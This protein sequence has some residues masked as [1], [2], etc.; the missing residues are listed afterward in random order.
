MSAKESAT[1]KLALAMIRHSEV[2]DT[3]WTAVANEI[4][5]TTPHAAQCRWSKYKKDNGLA[6]G[7][8]A[9]AGE[10]SS[11][12]KSKATKGKTAMGGK[13]RKAAEEIDGEE[14]VVEEP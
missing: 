7:K 12:P 5:A 8:N 4:G 2:S 9:N 3:N 1:E 14:E 10:G 13:K 6:M 11:A